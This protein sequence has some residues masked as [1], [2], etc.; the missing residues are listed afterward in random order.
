MQDNAQ[1]D[2]SSVPNSPSIPTCVEKLGEILDVW[3]R[4]GV[5]YDNLVRSIDRCHL[6]ACVVDRFRQE[7]PSLVAA[8]AAA[9]SLDSEAAV[10]AYL[11]GVARNWSLDEVDVYRQLIVL[12]LGYISTPS[13]PLGFGLW[14]RV[15]HEDRWAKILAGTSLDEDGLFKFIRHV[16]EDDGVPASKLYEK[17]VD[18]SDGHI[19]D[20]SASGVG[21]SF[22]PDASESSSNA[23]D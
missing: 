10:H 3:E 7:Q 16:M 1:A 15:I 4:A 17:L 9:K 22:E 5:S 23:T 6:A 12:A 21:F 18:L 19:G 2:N 8:V 11:E 13:D 20:E 14:F